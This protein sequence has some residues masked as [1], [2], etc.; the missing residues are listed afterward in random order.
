MRAKSRLPEI[1][2]KAYRHGLADAREFVVAMDY[3]VDDPQVMDDQAV[4][5]AARSGFQ[6]HERE[7]YKLHYRAG[8]GTGIEEL[9]KARS[10]YVGKDGV[11]RLVVK[12][13]A[14]EDPAPEEWSRG[15]VPLLMRASAVGTRCGRIRSHPFVNWY[16]G[17]PITMAIRAKP[18]SRCRLV[19]TFDLLPSQ[20]IWC[21]EMQDAAWALADTLVRAISHSSTWNMEPV[22]LRQY[23]GSWV[24]LRDPPTVLEALY[25]RDKRGVY[26]EIKRGVY[27][28]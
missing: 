25:V 10:S 14:K 3:N 2:R 26:R 22:M 18:E 5:A 24:R 16:T 17:Q 11:L 28:V 20:D 6:D 15:F 7:A 23:D 27:R 9:M 8:L 13:A 12:V 21:V 19:R 1:G 4:W